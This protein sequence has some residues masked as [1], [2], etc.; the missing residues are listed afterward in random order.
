[1]QENEPKISHHSKAQYKDA[2]MKKALTPKAKFT[3]QIDKH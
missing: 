3:F 2:N 1:M